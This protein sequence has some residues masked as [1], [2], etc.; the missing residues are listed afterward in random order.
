MP[1]TQPYLEPIKLQKQGPRVIFLANQFV[2]NSLMS[3][4]DILAVAILRRTKKEIVIIAPDAIRETLSQG[5]SGLSYTFISSEKNQSSPASASTILGGIQTAIAYF[6][7]AY[8]SSKWLRKHL[9]SSDMVYLTGDFICNAFPAWIAKRMNRKVHVVANFFHRIPA[10]GMRQGNL[11]WVSFFS[12]VL[13]TISLK[14]LEKIA[15][16]FFV[17]SEIGRNELVE[18]G[19][20]RACVVVS[21]A[22]VQKENIL[23]FSG[24]PKRKN[25][26]IY[27]GRIN[28]SK[29][30]FDLVRILS[31]L[32]TLNPEFHCT[33]VGPGAESDMKRLATLGGQERMTKHITVTGYVD[34]DTKYE[35]LASSSALL[36]PS[37]EEGYGI[38][39]QEALTLGVEVVCYDLPALRTLF[40]NSDLVQFVP[41]YSA[42]D[43]AIAIDSILRDPGKFLELQ[44]TNEL[45]D[46]DDVYR[47][48]AK[49]F[50][51]ME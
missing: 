24:T 3:G 7:R 28:E 45:Q 32:N 1:E 26:L 23:R 48:Q 33:M 10:P 49:H 44:G 29:G 12:R 6:R 21:G 27:I 42:K 31:I 50:D 11:Y 37:K 2:G 41:C 9:A 13:Q 46:W 34:E 4:G 35:L 36:L 18:F 8:H 15:G 20:D 38:V 16:K 5:L 43:F 19:I 47:I 39:V 17:L 25:H 30:A 22:G 14:L 51:C 40:G